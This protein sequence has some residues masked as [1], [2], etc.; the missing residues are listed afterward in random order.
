MMSFWVVPWSTA[1]VDPV[2]LGDDDV[3]RQQPR[4]R[5][6]DRHRRVHAVERDPV[7]QRVHVAL[8]R[9]RHADLAD[10]AARE[11]VIGVVAR[12]RRQVEGDGEPG[13]ALGEVAAGTARWTVARSSGRRRSASSRGGPGFESG[14]SMSGIFAARCDPSTS[15]TSA[16]S[17]SSAAGRSTA[18]WSIPGPQ[19]CEDDAARGARRRA[20]EGA[21]PDAHPLRPRRRGGRAR[22]PLAGPAG[23]RPRARRAAPGRPGAG[24]S[25]APRGCTAARRASRACGARSCPVPEANLHVLEGG[26]TG[27]EGAF[28]RRVHARPRLPPRLLPARADRLGLRRRHGRR[29]HPA[30]EL[31]AGAD[32]AARHRR[33]GVGALARHDRRLGARRRSA[34]THFGPGRRPADAARARAREPAPRRPSFAERARPRTASSRPTRAASTSSAGEAADAILQAAPPDQLFLGPRALARSKSRAGYPRIDG[35]D[36]RAPADTRSRAPGWAATG[37]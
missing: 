11:L 2:L 25:P 29:A 21:A 8:V 16:A 3:E 24:S 9:D 26:E 31:H 28:T 1:R 22:A 19:S 23:L 33:R 10:L 15:C 6:V 14:G 35:R 34:L 4:R 13:L 32:A 5:R 12:L 7:H 36:D 18:C 30:A 17:T 20:P 37:A 27:V